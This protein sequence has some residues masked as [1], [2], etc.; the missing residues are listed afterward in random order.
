MKNALLF[1]VAMLAVGGGESGRWGT[2]VQLLGITVGRGF[3]TSARIAAAGRGQAMA[4]WAEPLDG[5]RAHHRVQYSTFEPGRGWQ[6]AQTITAATTEDLH[7]LDLSLA[8]NDAGEA[9]LA[10]LDQR[11]LTVIRYARERGWFE[12]RWPFATGRLSNL[13]VAIGQDGT[14]VVLWTEPLQQPPQLYA[15]RFSPV[16]GWGNAEVISSSR[17]PSFQPGIGSVDVAVDARGNAVATWIQ[18]IWNPY[19]QSSVWTSHAENGSRWSS[20]ERIE[21]GLD[22][23]EAVLGGNNRGEAIV[24]WRRN[25]LRVS[26]FRDGIWTEPLSIAEPRFEAARSEPAIGDSGDGMVVWLNYDEPDAEPSAVEAVRFDHRKRGWSRP[27]ALPLPAAGVRT[28]DQ[29]VPGGVVVDGDGNATVVWSGKPGIVAY[30]YESGLGWSEPQLVGVT[31]PFS[32]VMLGVDG[33]GN[34]VVLWV[35]L[36]GIWVNRFETSPR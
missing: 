4:V 26:R 23:P 3:R 33:V 10:L 24:A 36:D 27:Q 18:S 6:A 20:A 11:G 8:M 2:P 19:S 13:R 12:L 15:S 5:I 16:T 31:N 1:G 34:V 14:V 22:Y 21:D 7:P 25:D 32:E 17:E 35:A 9:A 29:Q 30:R 28:A